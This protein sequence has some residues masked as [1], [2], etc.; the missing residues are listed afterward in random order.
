M[1][2][3][4]V[5]NALKKLLNPYKEKIKVDFIIYL[6]FIKHNM[7]IFKSYTYTWQQLAI[8]KLALFSFGAIIGSYWYEFFRANLAVF[9]ILLIVPAGYILYISLKK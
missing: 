4:F 7:K 3:I 1:I 8:F 6:N 5:L 9:I 2:V